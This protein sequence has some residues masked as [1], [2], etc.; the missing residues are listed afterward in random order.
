MHYQK[1]VKKAPRKKTDGFR[2]ALKPSVKTFIFIRIAI[3]NDTT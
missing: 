1:E 3:L 2:L